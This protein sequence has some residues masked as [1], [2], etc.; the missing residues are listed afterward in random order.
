MPAHASA[1]RTP[2][3]AEEVMPPAY[4]APSPH[5][6]SPYTEESH[7]SSLI[8]RTGEEVRVSTPLSTLPSELNTGIFF[9]KISAAC[10]MVL[11]TYGGRHAF[12]SANLY[13]LLQEGVTSRNAED[14]FFALK[15]PRSCTG[16]A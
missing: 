2:S 4:P 9:A 7:F 15:S 1:T 16:G 11:H 14:T 12:I 5:G 6:I 3:T 8:M 10:T 13:P